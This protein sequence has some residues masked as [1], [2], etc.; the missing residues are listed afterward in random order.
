MADA[1]VLAALQERARLD[2]REVYFISALTGEGVEDVAQAMWRLFDDLGNHD[3]LV[4]FKE[5][6][7]LAATGLDVEGDA[8]ES[9]EDFSG[10][11]VVWTRE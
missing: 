6:P 11:E 9:D 4:R 2:N 3:P 1:E 7:E 10:I 5:H 8:A